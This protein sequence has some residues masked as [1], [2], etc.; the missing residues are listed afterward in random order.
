LTDKKELAEAGKGAIDAASEAR[1]RLGNTPLVLTAE[2]AFRAMQM[3][4]GVAYPRKSV[5]EMSPDEVAHV[6][7]E[8]VESWKA[9]RRLSLITNAVQWAL[10]KMIHGKA[11]VPD[12]KE[13]LNALEALFKATGDNP[14][15]PEVIEFW[16]KYCSNQLDY[17]GQ[18]ARG[19]TEAGKMYK[20]G[21][22]ANPNRRKMLE[23]IM[24]DDGTTR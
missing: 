22:L 24:A 16:A 10:N 5:R 6:E 7:Y 2:Q 20:G 18:A 12:A 21:S 1:S 3:R 4:Y 17:A 11:P 13:V 15:R 8:L 9:F 23:D 14:S 19:L